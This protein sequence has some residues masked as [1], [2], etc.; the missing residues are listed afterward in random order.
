MSVR[1][2]EDGGGVRN[3]GV[4]VINI[5]SFSYY[6]LFDANKVIHVK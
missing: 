4:V 3:V 1:R 2:D 6:I 5:Y